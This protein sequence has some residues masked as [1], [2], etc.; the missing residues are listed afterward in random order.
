[1]GRKSSWTPN[2]DQ[3]LKNLAQDQV[4][5]ENL[6]LEF[7][8]PISK[9]KNRA[10]TLDIDL[11]YLPRKNK[12][13]QEM[14]VNQLSATQL[15]RMQGVK[16]RDAGKMIGSAIELSVDHLILRAKSITVYREGK[17]EVRQD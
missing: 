7:K 16:D 2:Q 13:D 11:S 1:M 6:V 5:A 8:M 10:K 9:I 3:V 17:L 4:P 12:K 15:K 14:G